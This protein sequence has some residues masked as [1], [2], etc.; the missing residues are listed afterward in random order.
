MTVLQRKIQAQASGGQSDISSEDIRPVFGPAL[1]TSLELWTGQ[2]AWSVEALSVKFVSGSELALRSFTD[3][4]CCGLAKNEERPILI[5]VDETLSKTAVRY[6]LG[7]SDDAEDAGIESFKRFHLRE[8]IGQILTAHHGKSDIR[9]W[10]NPDALSSWFGRLKDEKFCE[11]EWT[12]SS[13]NADEHQTLRMIVDPSRLPES[14]TEHEVDAEAAA[15]PTPE[16]LLE[17][18]GP[19]R[20]PIQ[21]VGDC[22]TLSIAECM[23]LEI[24]QQMHLPNLDFNAVSVRLASSDQTLTH[25]TLG[26]DA[27]RKAIRLNEALDPT[28]IYGLDPDLTEIAQEKTAA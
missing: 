11:M 20:L 27:G 14:S 23:R 22:V 7:L 4:S 1:E 5:T 9:S 10:L 13:Q 12:L 2:E 18:L 3:E 28:F 19:C 25:A 15:K 24:G 26:T 6:A 21:I 8:L 16:Y 17:R